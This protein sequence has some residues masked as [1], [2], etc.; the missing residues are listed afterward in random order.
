MDTDTKTCKLQCTT[1]YW[2]NW[3]S[4]HNRMSDVLDQRCTSGNCKHWDYAADNPFKTPRTC[5]VCWDFSEISSYGTWDGSPSYTQYEITG[6]ATDI[7]FL[8]DAYTQTCELVCKVGYWSNWDSSW[9]IKSNEWDQRCTSDNCKRFDWA[10]DKATE[11]STKCTQCWA[12]S[13]MSVGD[14]TKFDGYRS[15]F[16]QELIAREPSGSF[17]NVSGVCHLNCK[18]GYWANMNSDYNTA[19][20]EYDQR[21]TSDNC[22]DWNYAGDSDPPTTC[23]S[24]W[25]KADM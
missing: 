9:D 17:T 19:S 11:P 23:T 5:T 3:S 16:A 21:C 25:R 20:T 1:N 22:R 10:A 15:Y 18:P 12:D 6:V 4:T 2:A 8:L 14:W 7:P 13:D 24:C